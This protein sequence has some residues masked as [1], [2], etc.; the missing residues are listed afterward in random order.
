MWT[1][2]HHTKSIY[3]H[4]PH[5]T[6]MRMADPPAEEVEELLNNVTAS[7][8]AAGKSLPDCNHSKIINVQSIQQ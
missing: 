2:I 5:S 6:Q 1:E 8:F 3:S 4:I 7:C